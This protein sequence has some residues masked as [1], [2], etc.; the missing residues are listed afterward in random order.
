MRSSTRQLGLP[1]PRVAFMLAGVL[2]AAGLAFPLSSAA[3]DQATETASA[4]AQP[5]EVE[6]FH[7][8]FRVVEP[9]LYEVA[10]V[11]SVVNTSDTPY[12]AGPEVE[13]RGA[14]GL[15]IPVPVHAVQI[16]ALPPPQGGLNPAALVFEP[17]RLLHLEPVAPGIQ[18]IGISYEVVAGPEGVD[19]SYTLPYPTQRVSLLVGGPAGAAVQVEAPQLVRQQPMELGAQGVFAQWSADSLPAGATVSFRIGPTPAPL[20]SKS[21]ALISF[22]FAL[23]VAIAVSIYG[24]RRRQ[25]LALERQQVIEH[26]AHLDIASGTGQIDSSEYLH[27][28]GAALEQLAALDEVSGLA[29]PDPSSGAGK[30]GDREAAR[31][32]SKR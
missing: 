7:L 11:M 2:L 20:S 6:V 21:L 30:Q 4:S 17:T 5:L 13:G 29:E 3:Q 9:G 26:I 8:I 28:R 12:Q 25:D 23:V 1:C 27:Q 19:V 15:V 32:R 18:Q 10:Q 22:S 24:G 31:G 14:A 16:N